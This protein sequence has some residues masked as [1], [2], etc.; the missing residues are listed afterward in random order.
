MFGSNIWLLVPVLLLVLLLFWPRK[1]TRSKDRVPP[2][3]ENR[4]SPFFIKPILQL[5]NRPKLTASEEVEIHWHA[6]AP[7][8]DWS[9]QY[10]QSAQADWKPVPVSRSINQNRRTCRKLQVLCYPQRLAA[11]N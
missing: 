5:G 11:R 2:D 1:D 6:E 10:R 3:L 4:K 9:V 8:N 7:E